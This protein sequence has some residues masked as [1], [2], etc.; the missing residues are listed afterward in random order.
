MSFEPILYLAI[1]VLSAKL[2][3]ELFRRIKQSTILGNVIAGVVV[4]PALFSIVKPV[5]EIDLFVSIGV[6]FLFF[7][8]GLEE[9]DLAGL[10]KVLRKRI[11]AGAAAGFLI[12][13]VV[14]T[15]FAYSVDPNLVKSMAIASVIGAS[16]LGV[17]AKV[18]TD[19]GKLKSTVGLEIFTLTAIVEFIAIIFV[20]VIIQINGTES[21]QIDEILWLFAKM[22]I[23]FAIAGL[24]SVFVL[25]PFFRIIQKHLRFQQVYFALVVG[26]I[27]LVAYFAEISGIHGAIGAL[28]LGIAVSRMNKEEYHEITHNIRGLGYGIFIPI[29]FAG[30]GLHFSTS[31]L[32]FPIWLIATYIGLIVGVKYVASY[33]AVR[34]AKMKP[35]K[36]VAYGVMSK[37]AVD[38][39]LMLSLLQFGLL[40]NDLFSLLVF[41]TLITMI[42]S[43]VELQRRLGK[44]IHVKVGTNEL[45]LMP[46]YFRA[47]V[48]DSLALN[49]V[50]TNFIRASSGDN[51]E[52][53]LKNEDITSES[54]I[55]VFNK[56]QQLV[57]ITSKEFINKHKSERKKTLASV[58]YRKFHTANPNDYLYS[59]I[60]K[61][62]SQEVNFVP[63]I[64]EDT[65]TI[66][67]VVSSDNVL[68]LLSE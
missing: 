38:L 11:F 47:V 5:S 63:V 9:I 21:P 28:M 18:L 61:I 54:S 17:T 13:F 39:A 66:V 7:L 19:L 26:I 55:L 6:F 1:L 12:P 24:V 25:Q 59:V 68:R 8:I 58:M 33:L 57:G 45:A 44:T 64:T 42:I 67:G 40:D 22:V 32:N 10:F 16:S 4:G 50:G 29:F 27:L 53:F 51:I 15:I 14:G 2:L 43:S 49:A 48:S 30:I 31:F 46:T 34:I 3:G 23:F 35:A 36:T 41:G 20:S 56:D 52:E 37:G 65:K 60:Q 62:N